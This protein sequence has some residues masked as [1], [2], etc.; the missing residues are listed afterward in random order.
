VVIVNYH[1][2][3]ETAQLTRQI[4]ASPEGRRRAVEVV[5]VDNHSQR[6]RLA[7]RLRRWPGVSLRR[8]K[9]NRGFARAVNEACRLSQGE[10]LLLLNPDVT[11]GNGFLGRV[12]GLT[13]RLPVEDASAGIIGFHLQNSDGTRQGSVGPFPT[14]ASTLM[15]FLRARSRRKYAS[16]RL[17][18]PSRVEWAT[19]CCL[20]VRRQCLKQ[21]GGL[22]EEFFLYYEDV[23]LCR[24]AQSQ[25]WS[26]RFEPGLRVTHHRPLH[27]R[28]LSARLRV[29]TRHALLVYSSKHW[30]RWQ[31]R[32]LA[33]IVVGEAWCRR[34][35]ALIRG[36][37]DQADQ[38]RKLAAIARQLVRGRHSAARRCLERVVR[39]PKRF[40]HRNSCQT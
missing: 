34:C 32:V 31:F 25:G 13:A 22:D 6:H 19:G 16:P 8:W 36:Q 37:C 38:F 7:S 1:Q 14:L 20:L 33:G 35:W 26:V 12:L 18:Q 2:W 11:L 5:I 3:P 24:R 21:L 27:G 30:P 28:P 9:R 29:F 17:D 10:W 15:R 4:L 39:T 23:D 40:L